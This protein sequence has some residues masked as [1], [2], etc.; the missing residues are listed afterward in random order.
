MNSTLLYSFQCMSQI[1]RKY[2]KDVLKMCLTFIRSFQ[3]IA[4]II[5]LIMR[6]CMKKMSRVMRKQ[7][8]WFQIWSHTNQVVQLQKM[9]RGLKFQTLKVE[10]LY[11]LFSEKK[12]CVFVFA[13][14]KHWFSHDGLKYL[15]SRNRRST[16]WQFHH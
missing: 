13:Y 11:Y 16:F 7:T 9:A 15:F 4:D 8:F 2:A 1:L 10:G 3:Y 12:I 6:L 14:A 5:K